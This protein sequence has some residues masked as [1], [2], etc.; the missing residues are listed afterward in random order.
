MMPVEREAV[1]ERW[2]VS[3]ETGGLIDR[4]LALLTK[5]QATTQLVAPSTLADIW[6]RH[7]EDSLQLLPLAQNPRCWVDLGSGGGFPGLVV[8]IVLRGQPDFEMHLVESH[9]RKA[10][11]LR[12]VAQELGLRVRVHA[13][14]AEVLAARFGTLTPY[15]P[16]VV[17]ARALASLDVLLDLSYPYLA[18]AGGVALFPKGKHAEEELTAAGKNWT[19]SAEQHASTTDSEARLLV[20]RDVKPKV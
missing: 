10:V 14:R 15:P 8:A 9:V 6:V 20:L 5:W 12:T 11:F 13:E 7:V 16:D 4:Y 3:R 2:G 1:L 17:S 19:F 18:M